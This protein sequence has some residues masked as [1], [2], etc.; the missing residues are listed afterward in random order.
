MGFQCQP[1]VKCVN[2]KTRSGHI[3]RTV[4]YCPTL[5]KSSNNNNCLGVPGAEPDSENR[6]ITL[7]DLIFRCDSPT[8]MNGWHNLWSLNRLILKSQVL[9]YDAQDIIRSCD[10]L[11]CV[12]YYT[13]ELCGAVSPL[14]KT[15]RASLSVSVWVAADLAAHLSPMVCLLLPTTASSKP[16]LIH[17][18]ATS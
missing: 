2:L 8:Q 18:I 11:L 14:E 17:I 15:H 7:Q 5:L 1:E 13:M 12:T 10:S 4:H 16:K 3:W 6:W 9:F